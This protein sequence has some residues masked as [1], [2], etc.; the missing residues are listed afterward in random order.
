MAFFLVLRIGFNFAFGNTISNATVLVDARNSADVNS[1]F[2][3]VQQFAGSLG[4][5]FLAAVLA[6][7]QNNGTGSL[8][9][10]T[11]AGGRVDYIFLTVLAAVVL[12]A[13]I[14]N[15]RLQK[16]GKSMVK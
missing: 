14:V 5:V 2:N 9:S 11:Y 4:T 1:I 6:V 12:C 16:Q 8:A 10:R 7:F 13:I 3:M 15:Y